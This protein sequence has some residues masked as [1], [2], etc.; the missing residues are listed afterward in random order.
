MQKTFVK[1]ALMGVLLAVSMLAYSQPGNFL[2]DRHVG[3]GVACTSCHG[4]KAPQPGAKVGM[5]G[6]VSCHGD[7]EKVS[8]RTKA[9]G[10]SPDPHYN[11]LVGL[12]C[13]ECH[14]GHKQSKL[15]CSTCHFVKFK[16]P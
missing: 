16:V 10:L 15:V 4:D 7:T 2:A 11:H 12:N 6:C 5:E 8:E 14:Q 1:T 3:R 9:K 13:L